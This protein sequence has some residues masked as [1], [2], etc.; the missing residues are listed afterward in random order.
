MIGTVDITTLI[1]DYCDQSAARISR[2]DGEL[3]C[4][5]DTKDMYG[6]DWRTLTSALTP[7]TYRKYSRD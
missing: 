5:S 3:L 2:D 4:R 1:C 6:S 7:G